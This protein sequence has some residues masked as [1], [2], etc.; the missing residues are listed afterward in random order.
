MLVLP[1]GSLLWQV[2]ELPGYLGRSVVLEPGQYASTA[3]LPFGDAALSSARVVRSVDVPRADITGAHGVGELH[4]HTRV[5]TRTH[6][7]TQA[8]DGLTHAQRDT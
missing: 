6:T 7:H 4:T 3:V 2:F 5:H 8:T 1:A